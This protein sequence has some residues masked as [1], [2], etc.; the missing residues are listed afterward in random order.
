M[1]S[2]TCVSVVVLSWVGSSCL[3]T[4]MTPGVIIICLQSKLQGEFSSPCNE[5]GRL[6]DRALE[7]LV[8]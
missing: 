8:G 2:V 3:G 5:Y 4:S 6:S 7:D 1:H